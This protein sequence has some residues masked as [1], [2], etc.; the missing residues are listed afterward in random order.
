MKV[1]I[2]DQRWTGGDMK[3]LAVLAL[4]ALALNSAIAA[5]ATAGGI[6]RASGPVAFSCAPAARQQASG[7][8]SSPYDGEETA[9]QRE[10]KSAGCFATG[11]VFGEPWIMTMS[12]DP[13]CAPGKTRFGAFAQARA[14][15][16]RR[17]TDRSV[18]AA[19]IALSNEVRGPG[20]PALIIDG[21]AYL[22]PDG[23]YHL[24][25]Q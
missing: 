17:L 2:Q 6:P 12:A 11:A 24:R 13:G 19:A 16:W 21:V 8:L 14:G 18:C 20:V 15:I 4:S 5:A 10:I 1:A 22:Q 25:A 7:Q 23:V 9:V 3:R